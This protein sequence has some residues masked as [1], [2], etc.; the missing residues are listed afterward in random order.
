VNLNLGRTHVLRRGVVA[1]RLHE[2]EKRKRKA[3]RSAAPG[4]CASSA[5]GP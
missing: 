3:G 1:N 4:L 5:F 2:G